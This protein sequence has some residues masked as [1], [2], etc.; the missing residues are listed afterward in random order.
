MFEGWRGRWGCLRGEEVFGEEIGF[1]ETGVE[2]GEFAVADLLV[3][4]LVDGHC[5][6]CLGLGL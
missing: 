1:G 6:C 4:G 3:G 2:G 5:F